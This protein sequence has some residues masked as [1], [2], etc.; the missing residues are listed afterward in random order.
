MTEKKQAATQ[1]TWRGRPLYQ[2]DHCAFSTLDNAVFEAHVT[3]EHA[4]PKASALTRPKPKAAAKA[5]R[6]NPALTRKKTMAAKETTGVAAKEAGDG[7]SDD[8]QNG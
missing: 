5:R 3:T 6:P 2:C 7:Q 4:A 1:A 8:D